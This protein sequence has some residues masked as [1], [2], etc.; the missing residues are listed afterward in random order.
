[1]IGL[2]Y[3]Y[4]KNQWKIILKNYLLLFWFAFNTIRS[5]KELT[6][7]N[8]YKIIKK[9]EKTWTKKLKT[10][11]K[12]S[13]DWLF[14]SPLI[15]DLLKLSYDNEIQ[16]KFFQKKYKSNLIKNKRIINIFNKLYWINYNHEIKNIEFKK[17]FKNKELFNK[18][19]IK[20]FQNPEKEIQSFLDFS[21][22]ILEKAGYTKDKEKISNEIKKYSINIVNTKKNSSFTKF[23]WRK[24]IIHINWNR[25]TTIFH[26]CTHVIQRI[27]KQLYK[28]PKKDFELHKHNE[29][30]AN[31]FA[32]NLF[33][34][35]EEKNLKEIN[36][37]Y[38][39]FPKYSYLYQKIIKYWTNSEQKNYEIIKKEC[40]KLWY[41]DIEEIKNIYDRFFKFFSKNQHKYLY[42][43]ELLYQIWYEKIIEWFFK[44]NKT[45][46]IA[47]LLL[48][49]SI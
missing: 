31:F 21:F 27:I 40:I 41:T 30:I 22:L 9:I 45:Q 39:F 7:N 5:E 42:P 37:D 4:Y 17:Y 13:N 3:T 1:M 28:I 34:N 26:E 47:D 15:K 2:N 49:K 12:E 20:T 6:E 29:G 8:I 43:K 33:N 38:I 14:D 44:K 24:I 32:Y 11:I 25:K 36:L 35:I 46:H 48:Y 10:L 19:H 16:E 23:Q 18:Y